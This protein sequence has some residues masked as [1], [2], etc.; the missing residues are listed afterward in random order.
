MIQERLQRSYETMALD[1]YD[2]AVEL[3]SEPSVLS[4]AIA[5]PDTCSLLV[6]IFNNKAVMCYESGDYDGCLHARE[7]LVLCLN[8]SAAGGTV[9]K[10]GFL[11]R[12]DI[13]DLYGNGLLLLPP[14]TA[15]AA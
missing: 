5:N 4:L 15:C 3:V 10:A 7:L 2:A 12:Q 14:S 13:L 9:T 8:A 11:Q 6:V 1:Y